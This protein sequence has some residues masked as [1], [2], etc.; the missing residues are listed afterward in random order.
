MKVLIGGGGTGG[1][2]VPGIALYKEFAKHNVELLYVLSDRDKA[3]D[4]FELLKSDE[5]ICVSL[6]GISRRLSI[7]TIKQ[8]FS[9]F[10][11]WRQV[12][13]KIKQ[14]NP[15]FMVI[16]GGYLSNIV[17]LSALLMRKPLYILEQNS[18]A[19]IT[20]RF[21]AHFAKNIFTTFPSPKFIPLHK[22]IYTGN[23]LLYKE[24]LSLEESCALLELS[25]S[26]KPI[27]GISGGSQGSQIINNLVLKIIPFLIE[28]GYQIVWSLGT[29]EYERFDKENLL[30]SLDPYQEN[31]KIYRF[32]TRMDAFWSASR[33][34]LARSGAGTVSESLLFR[35]PSLF[36]PIFQSPDNHQYLNAKFLK[37]MSCAEILEEPT[38]TEQKLLEIIIMMMSNQEYYHNNFFI[39]EEDPASTIVSFLLLQ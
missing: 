23:P 9:I 19:G 2:L 16:T 33:L 15:D 24:L 17:A 27:I 8:L 31:I 22:E 12:F 11:A 1:H 38:L 28:K 6:T 5:R 35:T 21:W 29:K 39:R 14:F 7:S 26:T 4:I 13:K 32:I 25:S 10:N 37:D 20:N 30:S 36:I 3:Y 34:V 18:V